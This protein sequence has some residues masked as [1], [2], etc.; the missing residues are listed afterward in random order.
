VVECKAY[1]KVA[2]YK[3]YEQASDSAL[4]YPQSVPLVVFKADYQPPMAMLD[5]DDFI[6]LIK[7]RAAGERVQPLVL[8][9]LDDANPPVFEDGSIL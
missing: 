2:V 9:S 3:W 7:P 4:E 1:K 8:S 5:L 6:E